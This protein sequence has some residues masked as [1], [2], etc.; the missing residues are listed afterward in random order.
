M[1]ICPDGRECDQR[2]EGGRP[3]HGH[4]EEHLDGHQRGGRLGGRKQRHHH[5]EGDRQEGERWKDGLGVNSIKYIKKKRE[6][7]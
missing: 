1:A 3:V 5:V 7:F 6:Y 4:G 2:V